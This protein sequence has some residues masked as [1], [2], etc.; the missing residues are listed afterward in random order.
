MPYRPFRIVCS[1]FWA[2][3]LAC[4]VVACGDDD[5]GASPDA[6]PP[7]ADAGKPDAR[8]NNGGPVCGNTVVED[9]EDCDDGNIIDEDDCLNTCKWSCGDGTIQ[10][11]EKC[12]TAIA[13]GQPGACP[14]PSCDDGDTCTTDSASGVAC[15][16]QC[17]HG[18]IAAPVPGDQCC[19]E[20]A[21][22]NT[23]P[24]CAIGCGNGVVEAGESC[25]TGIAAGQPGACVTSCD[26]G[27]SCTAD[28][29]NDAGTCKA[30]CAHA[31]ITLPAEGDGCCPAGA[32]HAT[33][34]DCSLTCGDGLVSAG[35]TCDTDIA[36]GQP[37][38]CPTSCSDGQA[39]TTDSLVGGGTC[40]ATCAHAPVVQPKN[41]DGCC[42]PIGNANNDNDCSAVCGNHVPEPGE[43]CDVGDTTPGDGCDA[44][45]KFE[46]TAFRVSQMEIKDPHIY[47]DG[48]CGD[49]TAIANFLL[50]DAIVTDK[51]MPP[52]ASLDLNVI[53]VFRPLAQM[54]GSSE[55][56]ADFGA[57]CTV[58]VAP[59][60]TACTSDGT[61]TVD[62]NAT[63][64]TTGI[65][66]D[67]LPGTTFAGYSPAITK[68]AAPCF[69]S[70]SET[71]D[72]NL[73]T[74]VI[75]LDAAR[76]AGTYVGVPATS[77]SDGLI[78]GF[79]S[80][81]RA[82]T[83]VFPADLP[84]VGGK[85]LA[86]LLVG[87]DNACTLPGGGTDLDVGPDGTTQGW[88]FYINFQSAK[89]AYT[90]LP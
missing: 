13:A 28:V 60:S 89:I 72:V 5:D 88:Y 48:T 46:P 59:A 71:L 51:T 70:D 29:L 26:D 22:S 42:P 68:P 45:C 53:T 76:L 35:E 21:N 58:P 12:D 15:Q 2:L 7:A 1:M 31:E 30:E 82:R 87:G 67:T 6:S 64:A 69:T 52:D 18:T 47:Y 84:L 50:N 43:D 83:T 65:C 16:L 66:L 54:A 3:A 61:N 85:T 4:T 41:G 75:R 39:C 74:V 14:D 78:R 77:I 73:G 36:P 19:P 81:E 11:H 32:N 62:S 10:S 17:A 57:K 8:P 79:I 55:L 27:V 24:D 86:Q 38:A 20:G 37:G 63:N 80:K 33:D 9:G 34:S 40:T 23:D 44:V 56:E 25:D 49:I 90:L